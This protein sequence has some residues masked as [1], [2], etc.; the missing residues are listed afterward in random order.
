MENW[1]ENSG[2]GSQ[3]LM[4]QVPEPLLTRFL[5]QPSQGCPAWHPPQTCS[6]FKICHCH[7]LCGV[8]LCAL[9]KSGFITSVPVVPQVDAC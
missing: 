2:M 5:Q 7:P 1:G 3:V 6:V 4:V 8:R 9:R